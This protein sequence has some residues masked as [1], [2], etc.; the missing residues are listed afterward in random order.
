MKKYIILSIVFIFLL[1]KYS[2]AIILTL[3]KVDSIKINDWSSGQ[4]KLIRGYCA[5][6]EVKGK[7]FELGCFE[8]GLIKGYRYNDSVTKNTSIYIYKEV[9]EKS[10]N[11]FFVQQNSDN[12]KRVKELKYL[13]LENQVYKI[14]YIDNRHLDI[15]LDRENALI[16]K[17]SEDVLSCIYN[18]SYFDFKFQDSFGVGVPINSLFEK[19][20][21][22]I[23]YFTA[24]YCAPCQQVKDSMINLANSSKTINIV[25]VTGKLEDS[26][27]FE[28]N[29]SAVKKKY[30][31]D[32]QKGYPTY[33]YFDESGD[34]IPPRLVYKYQSKYATTTNQQR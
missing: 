25:F 13:Y 10:R 17:E 3:D 4:E 28:K 21:L 11:T 26:R 22:N 15:T 29:Y 31:T 33:Y 5:A 19:G 34:F 2:R 7:K 24:D 30:Y 20:K 9:E 12:K 32:F 14:K 23:I 18:I 1:S 8:I 6:I 16:Q 27:R